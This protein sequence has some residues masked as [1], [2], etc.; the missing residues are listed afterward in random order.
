L[1]Q[2]FASAFFLFAIHTALLPILGE[3]QKDEGQYSSGSSFFSFVPDVTRTRRKIILYS[4]FFVTLFNTVFALLAYLLYV[5]LPSKCFPNEEKGVGICP[6]ILSNLYHASH[7][8]HGINEASTVLSVV[9][10]LVCFDLLF[11]IPL[12]LGSA[13]P[14][15]EKLFLRLFDTTFG[16]YLSNILSQSK[17]STTEGETNDK[18]NSEDE[19][20]GG[21][22]VVRDGRQEIETSGKREKLNKGVNRAH[23]DAEIYIH[24]TELS[25]RLSS[26][27][28]YSEQDVVVSKFL[29]RF[30]LPICVLMVTLWIPSVTDVVTLVGGVVCAL[31]GYVLPPLLYLRLKYTS[32]YSCPPLF[33][34][35]HLAISVFGV[36]LMLIVIIGR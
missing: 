31:S 9:K 16:K 22:E 3:T 28:P 25:S 19:S 33:L 4:Y 12:L 10:I 14:T 1:P 34:F 18:H 24:Y 35:S 6:N 20:G 29:S 11:T 21:H 17:Q 32:F 15:C 23:S 30:L 7:Q 5:D 2:F 36:T 8:T 13:R 27:S 26:Q